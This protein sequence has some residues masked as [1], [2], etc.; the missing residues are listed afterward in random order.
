[1]TLQFRLPELISN[2]DQAAIR[3]AD[4]V[5]VMLLFGGEPALSVVEV[6]DLLAGEPPDDAHAAE[7]AAALWEE[8]EQL[9]DGAFAELR[10][11]ADWL[12]D[13]YPL[14]IDGDVASLREDATRLDVYRFL[15]L[16][17][18]RQ[19]YGAEMQDDGGDA[20]AIFEDFVT[21]AVGDYLGGGN[22][23]VRFGTAGGHRGSGLPEPLADALE[24]LANRLHEKTVEG[25]PGN[26]RD[27]GG[28]AVAWKPFGDRRA[29]QLTMVCQ[30]TI[31]EGDWPHKQPAKR[32]TDGR[33]IRFVARPILGVAFAETLSLTSASAVEGLSFESIPF[34]RLR[35][36]AVV[37][38]EFPSELLV[39]M[40][41]WVDEV[42][43][44]VPA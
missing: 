22:P 12:A 25:L 41:T 1:M 18:A 39:R 13:R 15:V 11:R 28:D 26:N 5:E 32:W 14:A 37:G 42:Q 2:P 43:G 44:R 4:W 36:L 6:T 24:D 27:Y 9:A 20:G 17:R 21:H 34:D 40:A 35:L 19:L 31:S 10:N 29:G 38:D 7:D 33:M 16:L 8:A 3:V 23:P 30:A